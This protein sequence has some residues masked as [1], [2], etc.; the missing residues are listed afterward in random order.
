MEVKI[1]DK[2]NGSID[3]PKMAYFR[4]YTNDVNV[5]AQNTPLECVHGVLV[6]GGQEYPTLYRNHCSEPSK[7]NRENWA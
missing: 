7:R 2:T 3:S 4:P 1:P 5:S 6:L